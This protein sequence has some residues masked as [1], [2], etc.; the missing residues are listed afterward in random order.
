MI[1]PQI[2][3]LSVHLRFLLLGMLLNGVILNSVRVNDPKIG[4]DRHTCPN[5]RLCFTPKKRVTVNR[6]GYYS[7]EVPPRLF[8]F[9][10]CHIDTE[11][12]LHIGLEQSLVGFVD[13]LDGD[14]FDISSDI[15]FAAKVKH[16]LGFR[17]AADVRAGET[18]AAHDQAECGD[19]QGLLRCADQGDVAVKAKQVEIGIDVVL[20]GDGIED[21][22]ETA[23]VLLHFVGVAGYDNFIGTEAERVFR[24]VGRSCEDDDVCPERASELHAHVPQ[25]AETDN[26][27]FFT[28][29]NTP[30]AQG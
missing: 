8:R 14:D 3:V 30:V 13:L 19:L 29:G 20:G 10:R 5:C 22:I 17:D 27:N 24:L 9:K 28:L 18:A 2:N 15:M 26:A 16:F 25:P 23:S 6:I 1:K 11:A 21:E 7:F 12:V 4:C